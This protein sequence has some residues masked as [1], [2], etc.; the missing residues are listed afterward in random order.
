M[1]AAE[2]ISPAFRT[3]LQS[4]PPSER[5]REVLLLDQPGLTSGDKPQRRLTPAERS[6]RARTLKELAENPE[7]ESLLSRH[8]ARRVSDQPSPL[9]SVLVEAPAA[10]ILTLESEALVRA[11]LDN[12]PLLP[13]NGAASLQVSG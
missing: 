3:R 13:P 4:C 9:G 5:V 6:V 1:V 10:G 2:K 12:Q 7:I 11:V 8:S